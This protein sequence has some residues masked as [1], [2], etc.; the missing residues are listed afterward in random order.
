MV[1]I[2]NG[3]IHVGDGKILKNH[4]ILINNKNIKKIA[5]TIDKIDIERTIDAT[6]KEI[7]PGF[8]DPVSSI[9]S[10][11]RSFSI[12]D[13][14]EIS[15]PVTPEAKIKY[16]F[17]HS[18]IMFEELYKVGITTIGASPGDT[19]VIGGQ[20]AVFKTWG[21]NS[22]R[23]LIKD[24]VGLKG[25]VINLIKDTYGKD[26]KAPQTRMEIF[27]L[28]KNTFLDVKRKMEADKDYDKD[29]KYRIIKKVLKREIP[30]FITAHKSAEIITLINI[31]KEF[32]I[33]LVICGAYQAAR[34]LK[35][36][37][38]NDLSVVIGELVYLTA[39]NYNDTDLYKISQLQK[40]GLPVSFTLTGNSSTGGKV[41]YLWNVIELYRSG[42]DSEDV[43]KMMTLN[44]AKILGV[45]D[46][47]GTLEE[48]KKADLVIYSNN[49]IKYYDAKVT[50]T[51]IGGELAYERGEDSR[52]Y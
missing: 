42:I 28:L 8:I 51:F 14:N 17:N 10:M 49:P 43:L 7:F 13:H 26:N 52:C 6:D 39:K 1:I 46:N 4:D 27:N 23:M 5:K 31:L 16:A 25:S 35:Y 44:P 38:E 34:T 45:E 29:E 3:D 48:G 37:K 15:D 19:N 33:K 41:M 21:L 11:D 30:L 32:N 36:I 24:P 47:L 18:E 9:G 20:M 50:H 40:E 12:N 22:K 2:K